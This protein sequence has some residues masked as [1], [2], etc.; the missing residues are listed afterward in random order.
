MA[1]LAETLVEEWLNRQSSLTVRVV[2]DL[3]N[4][5]DVLAVKL[6][7]LEGSVPEAWHVEVQS[8]FRPMNYLTPLPKTLQADRHIRALGGTIA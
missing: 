5:I 7:P 6:R 2:R 8:R 1:L 4:E 3:V